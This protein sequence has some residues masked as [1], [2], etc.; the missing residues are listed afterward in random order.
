M[1]RDRLPTSS[2]RKV[3]P[4]ESATEAVCIQ[5]RKKAVLINVFHLK[6]KSETTIKVVKSLFADASACFTST[7]QRKW[8]EDF[9]KE[10]IVFILKINIENNECLYQPTFIGSTVS[11][12][13]II[14]EKLN[15]TQNDKTQ[16]SLS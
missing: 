3:Y 9:A 4:T 10:A 16:Y 6:A 8:V 1:D 12:N 11:E 5:T 14:Y 15:C 13:A 2:A 7:M